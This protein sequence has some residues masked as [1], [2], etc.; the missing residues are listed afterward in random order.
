MTFIASLPSRP[1][2]RSARWALRLAVLCPVLVIVAL[3]AHRGGM[4]ATP[5]FV[6]ALSV[7]ALLSLLTLV[8][9]LAGMRSLWVRGSKGGRRIAWAVFLMLPVLAPLGVAVA[10]AFQHPA[11]AEAT[12]DPADPPA[13]ADEAPTRTAAS[14]AGTGSG[15]AAGLA[16]LRYNAPLDSVLSA[17]AEVAEAKRWR[18][19]ERRG[20]IGA[21]DEI[22]VSYEHRIAVMHMPVRFVVRIADEGD[23]SFIDVRARMPHVAHDLGT[24]VRLTEAFLADLDFAMIG[25]TDP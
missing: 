10:L 3:L 25:R 16:G 23:T 12:T 19:L 9:V 5:T 20:R 11:V 7:L 14:E 17:V 21:D 15:S 8:L 24:T 18:E 6:L 2:S 1:P 22:H 4:M 13:F